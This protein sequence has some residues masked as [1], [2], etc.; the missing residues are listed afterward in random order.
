M[1]NVSNQFIVS[2]FQIVLVSWCFKPFYCFD[3]SNLCF[4]ICYVRMLALEGV[5]WV[6]E[7]GGGPPR[8]FGGNATGF[9]DTLLVSLSGLRVNYP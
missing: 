8:S 5:E 4:C 6:F 9:L 1:V 7:K 3:V 2:M